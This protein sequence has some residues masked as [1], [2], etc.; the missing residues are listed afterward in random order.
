MS[1][2]LVSAV[3]DSALPAW[4]KPYAAAFASFAADDGSRVYPTIGRIARMVGRCERSTHTAVAELRRRRILEC[5]APSGH[6]T[7]T[8][9]HFNTAA[10]PYAGD[11]A[12]LPILFEQ[13]RSPQP[14]PAK[15]SI[16]SR[17]PQFA[18]A[19]TGSGLHPMG[20]VDCTRSV[21]DPSSTP[22]TRA[23]AR[24]GEYPKTGTGEL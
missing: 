1:G 7:A 5:I 18:Q 16:N 20:A 9:Y 10:L 12:Q 3:F 22:R 21:S 15:A 6:A 11:G 13:P 24:K 4:L 14:K 8:R 19:L 17:F 2:R 23:R